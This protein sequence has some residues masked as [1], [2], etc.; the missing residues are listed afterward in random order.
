M[1]TVH[2]LV[3]QYLPLANKIAYQRKKLLP[4]YID[5]E[6]LQSAAYMGLVEA[7]NRY[8]PEFSVNFMTYAYPRIK[9]AV[10]DYLRGLRRRG[11]AQS[12]EDPIGGEGELCVKD[13]LAARD[14]SGDDEFFETVSMRLGPRA[15]NILRSYFV[16]NYS[17]KELG[18]QHDL[19]EGRISQLIKEYRRKYADLQEIAA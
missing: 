10:Q 8:R 7:A 18:E 15:E 14:D 5:I 17:M 4:R 16:E 11:R 6:E 19:T 3:E 1:D 12:I 9:G 2:N 13:T